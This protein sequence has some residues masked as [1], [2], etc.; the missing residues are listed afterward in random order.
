MLDKL[1]NFNICLFVFGTLRSGCRLDYYMEG[2]A[3]QGLFYTQ[4]QLME[5]ENGSA[6]ID[7]DNKQA[8]TI[9]ELH[10]INF[11]CL[12]RINHL[13]TTW[14]DFPKAYGIDLVPV[15]KYN[16]QQTDFDFNQSKQQLAFC[17]RMR[18]A[19]KVARG[20]WKKRKNIMGEI[21]N[22]LKKSETGHSSDELIA[23]IQ[24]YLGEG[25]EF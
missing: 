7:F 21:A 23:H 5:S 14:G 8:A 15:W 25:F 19:R 22:F 6:Y 17:Y 4:G 16:P 2:S 18:K 13:E 9:G 1:K 10:H 3:Y 20:D 11:Y 12:Q 24:S